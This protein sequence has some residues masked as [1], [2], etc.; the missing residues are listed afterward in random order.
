MIFKFD[1]LEKAEDLEEL[2]KNAINNVNVIPYVEET[3]SYII[4]C[5][6]SLTEEEF[7]YFTEVVYKIK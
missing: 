3:K 6:Y 7:K 5:K 2:L 4:G 1:E